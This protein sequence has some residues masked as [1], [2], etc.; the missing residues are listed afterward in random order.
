[1]A[2]VTETSTPFTPGPIMPESPVN[3][4][5]AMTTSPNAEYQEVDADSISRPRPKPSRR[6]DKPQLSCNLCRRRK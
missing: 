1:M 2:L 3:P 4:G 6:R 5:S